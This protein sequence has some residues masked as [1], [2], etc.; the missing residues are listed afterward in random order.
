MPISANINPS[1]SARMAGPAAHLYHS[2][3][4]MTLLYLV[5]GATTWLSWVSA[6]RSTERLQTAHLAYVGAGALAAVT[7]AAMCRFYIAE[8]VTAQ[9]PRERAM[10]FFAHIF[11]FIGPLFDVPTPGEAVGGYFID[12]FLSIQIPMI[13]LLFREQGFVRLFSFQLAAMLLAALTEPNDDLWSLAANA[14]FVALL[15]LASFLMRSAF[16]AERHNRAAPMS[17]Q[18]MAKGVR[19]VWPAIALAVAIVY[20]IMPGHDYNARPTL[21]FHFQPTRR[22]SGPPPLSNYSRVFRDAAI[23]TLS[24]IALAW[25]I[26]RTR[27][28]LTRRPRG[29]DLDLGYAVAQ[30]ESEADDGAGRSGRRRLDDA[31][32][33]VVEA[34]ARFRRGTG[35]R[36]AK[37]LRSQTPREYGR[38]FGQA[39]RWRDLEDSMDALTGDF[40]N[41]RYGPDPASMERAEKYDQ[42]LKDFE[43]AVQ[44]RLERE[45]RNP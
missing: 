20:V 12:C 1:G 15:A 21:G 10:L 5:A 38:A 39:S 13:L 24:L 23:L 6:M 14:G 3:T 22:P 43:Q 9:S 11:F 33:L 36:V 37:P 26:D 27:R 34:Y 42:D 8:F 41:I 30:V 18:R 7:F 35:S 31:R 40:E 29:A 28:F 25:V 17:L 19:W 45:K 16:A 2:S 32:R 4:A 44:E